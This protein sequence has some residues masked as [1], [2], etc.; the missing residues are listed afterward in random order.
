M[1]EQATN[2]I[3]SDAEIEAALVDAQAG[4][5]PNLDDNSSRTVIPVPIA[6]HLRPM[7]R[8]A[9]P[10]E[11]HGAPTPAVEAT[12]AEPAA[13]Q[14]AE[15]A[16]TRAG[17]GARVYRAADCALWAVNRPFAWLGPDG[18]T[19]AGWLA[20]TTIVVSVLAMSLLPIFIPRRTFSAELHRQAQHARATASAPANTE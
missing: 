1:S 10:E 16:A 7:P 5:V 14:P 9:E 19:L 15:P 4:D 12:A 2:T 17:L 11:P 3:V 20:I 13:T 18:R 6:S 8:S